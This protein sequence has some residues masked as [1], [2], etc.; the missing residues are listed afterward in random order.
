LLRVL[1][2]REGHRRVCIA[3]ARSCCEAMQPI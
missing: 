2:E 3:T 1:D